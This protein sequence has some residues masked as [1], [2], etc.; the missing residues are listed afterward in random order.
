MSTGRIPKKPEFL[1]DLLAARIEWDLSSC[2]TSIDLMD[3]THT[4]THTHTH[5]VEMKYSKEKME[6]NLK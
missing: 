1:I 2:T 4:H 3:N 5:M 6:D